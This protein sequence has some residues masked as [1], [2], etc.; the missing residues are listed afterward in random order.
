MSLAVAGRKRQ[1]SSGRVFQKMEVATGN[2]RR[3]TVDKRYYHRRDKRKSAR[4]SKI[5]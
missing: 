5:T 1:T 3:P 4:M 2:A